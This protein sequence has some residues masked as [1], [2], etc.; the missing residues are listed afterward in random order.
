MADDHSQ[1]QLPGSGTGP[2]LLGDGV[3]VSNDNV[4]L[5]ME[6]HARLREEVDKLRQEQQKL[7]EEKEKGDKDKDKDKKEG[8]DD[9]D[10]KEGED[11]DKDKKEEPKEPAPERAKH[12]VVEHPIA[13]LLIIVGLIVLAL[14]GFFLWRYLQSYED[15]DDAQVDGHTIQVSSRINGVVTGVYIEDTQSVKKGQTVIDLDPRDYEVAL[16]Q[17][18]ANLAQQQANIQA[19]SPNVPITQTSQE[20]QVANAQ[21]DVARAEATVM[22][23]EHTYQSSLADLRQAE[24]Q[25]AN[26]AAE[27]RRYRAL[28]E[29]EEVS[30]EAYDQRLTDVR[31][32]EAIVSSRRATANAAK[33]NVDQQSAALGQ[34][35]QRLKEAQ[36]NLPR[37]IAVQK[38]T[39][40]TRRASAYASKSQLDLAKLNLSY[41][42]LFAPVDGIVGNKSVEVGMHITAGQELFALTPT[43]DIW[44]TANFK[45]TQIRRMHPGQSVTIHV[46]TL[47]QDF[48]GYIENMPGA[49]GARY[50]L[51]PPENATGNYVKVVQRLP[52]RLRFKPNQKNGERL[53]PGMSVEPKV[54]VQQ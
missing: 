1:A 24:A 26:A 50:S 4:A 9:K 12:W 36:V 52:V 29:K 47:A 19:Q 3:N 17:A 28:V 14:A 5:L 8:G 49:T 33:Q 46:D 16:S 43:D 53:R 40:A 41:C 11:K 34:A 38:A 7:K 20:T 32:Q 45:E 13:V 54:W 30:R 2:L 23:A 27:E 31:A 42:K 22:Q 21:Y 25:A 10:K 6:E 37:Q 51:L 35:R 39:E 18:E 48:D 44:V 15:T